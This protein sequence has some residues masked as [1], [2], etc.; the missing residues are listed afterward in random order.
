MAVGAVFEAL[1]FD[2]DGLLMDTESTMVDS[3]RAEWAFH[4]LNL[5]LDDSFWPG[6]GGDIS[7][8]RY[9]RLAALVGPA[10]DRAASHAR[11]TAYRDRM[12]QSMGLCPGI[13]EWLSA[14]PSLALRL[15]IASSSPLRWIRRHLSRVGAFGVFDVVATGDEVVAHKPDPGV[16]LLALDRLGLAGGSAIA[17]EDTPHG[18]TAARA[19]GMATVAIPNPFVPATRC[20]S[21]D[22]VLTSAAELPLPEVLARLRRDMP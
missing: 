12:N 4:G 22:L 18:V 1:V 20:D 9:D 6:H 3:W 19:A 13:R 5:D 8:H 15:A 10:F 14:A 11:R 16:Y 7:E 21:A 2:F 17:V